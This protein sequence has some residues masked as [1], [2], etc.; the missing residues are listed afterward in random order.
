MDKSNYSKKK[1]EPDR[2][3]WPSAIAIACL[4]KLDPDSTSGFILG[5]CRLR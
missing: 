5:I 3:S 1:K 2:R 4:K